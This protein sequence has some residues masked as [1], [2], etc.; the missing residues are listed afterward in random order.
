MDNL[1][2][3]EM[4]QQ[5]FAC[6]AGLMMGP[7]FFNKASAQFGHASKA[8][9][10]STA[11]PKIENYIHTKLASNSPEKVA[12]RL[13]CLFDTSNS[14]DESEY[15]F[16]LEA[17][18]AALESEEFKFA[19][20]GYG[21]ASSIAISV[22]EFSTRA[23]L[24]IPWIDIRNKQDAYKLD[25]LAEEIR[26]L[27]RK[28]S[29]STSHVHALR[30]ASD[31]LENCPWAGDKNIVDIITDG[32]NNVSRKLL[33][34]ERDS[35][36][37]DHNA[38]INALVTRT[39]T[40]NDLDEWARKYLITPPGIGHPNGRY[41]TPGFV[42]VVA[43]QQ[44]SDDGLVEYNQAMKFAFKRKLVLEVAGVELEEIQKQMAIADHASSEKTSFPKAS[45]G[46]IS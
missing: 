30:L 9:S 32:K 16:Q 46:E 2:R 21:G 3:R 13:V 26:G 11:N 37:N 6:S 24:Q 35:L 17:M 1:G 25:A 38:T 45:P 29:A 8:A 40:A 14:I 41:L 7:L 12:V 22:A 36:V 27:I 19:V 20:F 43:E 31:L 44:T 33:R 39:R 34:H 10:S 23:N 42:K 28:G 4:L 15:E 5:L 18:A